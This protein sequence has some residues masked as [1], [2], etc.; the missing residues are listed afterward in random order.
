[1]RRY[2]AFLI[3]AVIALGAL[4]H[5]TALGRLESAGA[6]SVEGL[7]NFGQK[8]ESSSYTPASM[9][10]QNSGGEGE[11]DT[12]DINI[13]I[14][15]PSLVDSGTTKPSIIAAVQES[16]SQATP[17]SSAKSTPNYGDPIATDKPSTASKV[18]P[19]ATFTPPNKTTNVKPGPADPI[20][21]PGSGNGRMEIIAETGIPKIHW[22]QQPEH[23]PIP[24][25]EIIQLPTGKPQPIPKIQ[26]QFTVESASEKAARED[27]REII[28]RPFHSLGVDTGR[29][30]GSKTNCP[31]SLASI[32]IPFADGARRWWILWTRCG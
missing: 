19:A 30:H 4:Y 31:Q 5:F 1:M 28:K 26:H 12:K 14:A 20:F 32:V 8:S 23:F 18:A 21:E 10:E 22:S 2:R 17:T 29:K 27:K 9:S 13:P 25:D 15:H 16:E 6:A 7:K 11:P 24:T 3:F